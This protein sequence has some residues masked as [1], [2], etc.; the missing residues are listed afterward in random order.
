MG[1]FHPRRAA[2]ANHG[3]KGSR[4]RGRRVQPRRGHRA[5]HAQGPLRWGD[6][7]RRPRWE[8]LRVPGEG[9]GHGHRRRGHAVQVLYGGFHGQRRP[10]MDVPLLRGIRVRHG[11]P[12]GRGA[13]EPRTALGR[14]PDE[15]FLRAGRYHLRGLRRA[16]RQRQ[17]RTGHEPLCRARRR[18]RAALH[19]GQRAHGG[20]AC[21]AR[22]V[23]LRHHAPDPGNQQGHDGGLPQR[24]AFLRA[25]PR[26]PGA[27][28]HQ[29]AHRDLWLR[30]LHP[31][32][33]HRRRVLGGHATHDDRA[34]PVRRRG[35]GWRQSQQIRRGLLRR[36][37]ARRAW[38][39]GLHG[40]SGSTAP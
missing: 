31:R 15:G 3:G 16:D 29:G 40:G 32:R 22:A 14:H 37:Q 27:G 19:P 6:G 39:R 2:Q 4:E 5:A 20:V 36:G 7:P 24:A 9:H 1:H 30:S 23:L 34:R 10:D 18:R 33:A 21:R 35:D 13:D 38:G 8:I 17:R 26:Q 28:R 25:V 11:L 12:A